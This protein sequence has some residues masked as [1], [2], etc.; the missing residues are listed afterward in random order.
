[1]MDRHT[2]SWTA[3]LPVWRPATSSTSVVTVPF[4]AT[5][6]P[7]ATGTAGITE[8]WRKIPIWWPRSLRIVLL[9]HHTSSSPKD[10]SHHTSMS[11]CLTPRRSRIQLEESRQVVD[12][13]RCHHLKSHS[14]LA[15][16]KLAKAVQTAA[17][18]SLP[19]V[20]RETGTRVIGVF[21]RSKPIIRNAEVAFLVKRPLEA[22]L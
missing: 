16:P 21:R 11:F 5:T 13:N 4:A 10:H 2:I 20:I 18:Q 1:M 6:R 7:S 19:T 9:S 3:I 15:H 14:T 8:I 17:V 12:H 22:E